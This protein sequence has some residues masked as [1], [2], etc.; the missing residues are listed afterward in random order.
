MSLF[1]TILSTKAEFDIH[2]S[3]THT[4]LQAQDLGQTHTC[5]NR[6]HKHNLKSKEKKR[7]E[8][9]SC[10]ESPTK[11]LC[12]HVILIRGKNI[13]KYDLCNGM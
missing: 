8:D 1:I 13:S 10:L 5:N 6:P 2:E 11:C 9:T 4:E 3:P 7:N 12:K